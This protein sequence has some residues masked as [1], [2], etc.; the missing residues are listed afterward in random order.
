M[1]NNVESQADSVPGGST[2]YPSLEQK[3]QKSLVAINSWFETR[4]GSTTAT[5]SS[6][7]IFYLIIYSFIYIGSLIELNLLSSASKVVHRG[8]V[9]LYLFMEKECNGTLMLGMIHINGNHL[10]S[11]IFKYGNSLVWTFKNLYFVSFPVI[12]QKNIVVFI[13]VVRAAEVLIWDMRY[14]KWI[15]IS[16]LLSHC[17]MYEF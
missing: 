14:K 7:F 17:H 10:V 11:W 9:F 16:E 12:F 3:P 1:P 5:T 8:H 6:R 4:E 2:C 13:L 15:W